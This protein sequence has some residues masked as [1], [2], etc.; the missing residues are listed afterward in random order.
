MK[1]LAWAVYRRALAS[2]FRYGARELREREGIA[3][4]LLHNSKF[5]YAEASP[6]P[7]HSRETLAEVVASLEAGSAN[8]GPA[9]SFGLAAL[10]AQVANGSLLPFPVR[11]NGLL[12][13]RGAA[14]SALRLAEL[15]TQGFTCF[16]LKVPADQWEPALELVAAHPAFRF[17]LD[18][19]G[20]LDS[21]AA[22]IL[23]RWASRLRNLEYV[24]EPGSWAAPWLSKAGVAFAADE[25]AADP[26]A[27][28]ALR[29]ASV[30]PAYWIAKPTV[31][32]PLTGGPA[33]RTVFTSSLEAEPGRRALISWLGATAERAREAA[34]L[35][36]GFL[37]SDNYCSDLPI[38]TELPAPTEAEERWLA[39]LEWRKINP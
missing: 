20:T 26:A 35:A 9:L 28:P 34:G 25:S 15:A 21:S 22:Q 2:P 37:F 12:P 17:R 29:A 7:G 36:T 31:S 4:R 5:I 16:K 39:G 27:W 30:P 11:S 23:A 6:L 8:P 3:L 38:Y 13:W 18:A 24:E 10:E 1:G 33:P 14:E 32:G 19:N